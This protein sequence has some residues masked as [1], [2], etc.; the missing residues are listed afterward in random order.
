MN[1]VWAEIVS[2]L[3]TIGQDTVQ[4]IEI[5]AIAVAVGVVVAVPLGVLLTRHQRVA[6]PVIA[7]IGF[8]QTIPSLALL[9]LVLP[10][11]GIGVLPALSALA[12][13]ALLPILRNTYVGV[14]GVP[15]A[16]VDSAQA[17]GMSR[18]QVLFQ[19][20]MPLAVPVIIAGIRLSTVYLIS[21][22]II[23]AEIGSGGLGIL[24]FEGLSTYDFAL[25]LAGA[26]PAALLAILAGFL[27]NWLQVRLTPAGIRSRALARGRMA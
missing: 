1:A 14:Q 6:E 9:A 27:F 21:W 10:I 25:I 7:I 12:L 16:V 8:L 20:E 2:N 18:A 26:V 19:V 24:I 23:A 17:M 4:H 13:Y 3:G 22:A 5:V 11:L 15:V